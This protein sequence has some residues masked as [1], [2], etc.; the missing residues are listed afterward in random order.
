MVLLI[1]NQK[2]LRFSF[3][4]LLLLAGQTGF[5]QIEG[6]GQVETQVRSTELFTNLKV[7]IPFA[8]VEILCQSMPHVEI[9]GD[10]N[11]LNHIELKHNGNKLI[12][13]ATADIRPSQ[14][15]RLKIGT[16][17]L[18]RLETAV[19]G[20]KYRV[21]QLETSAFRLLNHNADVTL[22]GKVELFSLGSEIGHTHAKDLVARKVQLSI[23]GEAT[24][25]LTALHS[26]KG[27]V[28]KYGE[29]VYHGNPQKVEVKKT[30]QT[31]SQPKEG[32][33]QKVKHT[34]KSELTYV[35]IELYNNSSREVDIFVKGPSSNP[36]SYGVPFESG[37]KRLEELPV[38]TKVY[39]ENAFLLFRKL[40][41]VIGEDTYESP[42]P[43]FPK[44]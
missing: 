6:N 25:E 36:F 15:L 35:S 32:A 2:F 34:E 26:V 14:Q 38:G 29:V 24:A 9:T 27:A 10:D 16:A 18:E 43:L 8:D 4:I 42:V 44:T 5:A 37:Q 30:N 41:F 23:W 13:R 11:L 21:H 12:L 39:H 33:A 31:L 28:S 3:W 19:G 22:D 40:L 17:F 20:G 7:E 1:L